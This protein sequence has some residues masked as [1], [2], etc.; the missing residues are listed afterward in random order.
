[1]YTSIAD[2]FQTVN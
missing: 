1:M 2:Y